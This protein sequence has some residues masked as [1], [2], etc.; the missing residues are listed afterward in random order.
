MKRLSNLIIVSLRVLLPRNLRNSVR[1]PIVTLKRIISKWNWLRG[2]TIDVA[3]LSDWKLRCH[4]IC[5]TEFGVFQTDPIQVMEMQCFERLATPGM[6]LIDV[7]THWGIFTLAALHFGGYQARVMGIEAS[8]DVVKVY[9]DNLVINGVSD[10]V[11][12]INAACGQSDGSLKMLTTGA[13][14]AD[15]FVIPTEERTDTIEVSQ[16]SVDSMVTTHLFKPTHLKIDVEGFEEEVLRGAVKTLKDSRPI[17]F[18]EL[19]GP[20][21]RRRR[22]LPETVLQLLIASGYTKWQKLDATPLTLTELEA[23][24]YDARFVAFHP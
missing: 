23:A 21:I 7:G 5:G 19:H 1:R 4:P 12:V 16:V 14:G 20:L 2:R 8:N 9:R 10:R 15:Y 22:L 11:V 13:G 6:Q 18:L 3:I 24:G 17:I